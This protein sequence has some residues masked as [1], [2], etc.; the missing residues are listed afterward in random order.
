MK[1]FIKD[2]FSKFLRLLKKSLMEN[3]IFCAVVGGEICLKMEFNTPSPPTTK[4]RERN[5][6]TIK[7]GSIGTSMLKWNIVS[8]GILQV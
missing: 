1:F 5:D 6:F 8:Y 4:V 3:I 7:N 2:F